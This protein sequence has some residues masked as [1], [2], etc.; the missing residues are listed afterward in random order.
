MQNNY[1]VVEDMHPSPVT[2]RLVTRLLG[3]VIV[4]VLPLLRFKFSI[5]DPSQLLFKALRRHVSEQR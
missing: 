2:P 3:A 4:P 5:G 1:Q